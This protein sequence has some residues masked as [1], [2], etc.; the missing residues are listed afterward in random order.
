MRYRFI[1]LFIVLFSINNG[2][3][4]DTIPLTKSIVAGATGEGIRTVIYTNSTFYKFI[5]EDN[6]Y[7]KEQDNASVNRIDDVE[8]W[9]YSILNKIKN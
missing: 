9:R 4:Q 8:K 3:S 5:L 1:I 7:L 2:F 6:Y